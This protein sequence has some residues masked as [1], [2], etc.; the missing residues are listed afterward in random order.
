MRSEKWTGDKKKFYG[1][2]LIFVARRNFEAHRGLR[3]S[4]MC[5]RLQWS[6]RVGWKLRA[7][8]SRERA[9]PTFSCGNGGTKLLTKNHEGQG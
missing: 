7:G 6:Y 1:E 3:W 8:W 2:E 4:R 5:G 9:M